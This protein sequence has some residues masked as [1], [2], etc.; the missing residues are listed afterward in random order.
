TTCACRRPTWS[1]R[2]RRSGCGGG[3]ATNRGRRP[4]PS[5]RRPP[6]RTPRRRRTRSPTRRGRA[7]AP[8]PSAAPPAA[9]PP[10]PPPAARRPPPARGALPGEPR[11]TTDRARQRKPKQITTLIFRN[12]PAL[13]QSGSADRLQQE[14]WFDSE[15]F[16][17]NNWFR[18]DRFGDGSPSRVG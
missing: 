12:S 8:T 9:S 4:R 6:R 11:E 10:P 15:P 14:G 1:G 16:L 17:V 18:S 5:P 7:R 13:A 2:R 3:G